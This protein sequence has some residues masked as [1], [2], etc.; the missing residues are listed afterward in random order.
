MRFRGYECEA[1]LV[2]TKDGYIL[3]L[4]RITSRRDRPV[5]DAS[6]RPVLLMHGCMLSSEV[7][8]CHPNPS[9]S[10]AFV[11]ADMG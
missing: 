6:K 1:H 11:L 3:V 2:V 9:Q 8:V 5:E 7:W 4:H 10:Y